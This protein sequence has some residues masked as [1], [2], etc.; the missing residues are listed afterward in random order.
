MPYATLPQMHLP[1]PHLLVPEEQFVACFIQLQPINLA[2]MADGASV[3]ATN[4]VH[5]GRKERKQ[6]KYLMCLKVLNIQCCL[7][8]IRCLGPN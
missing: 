5:L 4:K 8:G 3:V 1:H 6:C 7:V 2:V